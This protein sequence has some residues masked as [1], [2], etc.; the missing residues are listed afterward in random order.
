MWR[1]MLTYLWLIA[2]VFLMTAAAHAEQPVRTVID[3]AG[4]TVTLPAHIERVAAVGSVPVIHSFI[5]TMGKAD[6]IVN[7]MPLFA[8]GRGPVNPPPADP[9]PRISENMATET[10]TKVKPGLKRKSHRNGAAAR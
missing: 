4:R 9:K 1:R 8:Q 3:M 10:L 5:F 6:T 2:C 7:G